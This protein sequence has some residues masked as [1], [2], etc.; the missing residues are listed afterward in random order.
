[1]T[2]VFISYA[3]ADRNRVRLIAHGLAAEG[4]A[5]W[6]DP[7]IKPGKKWN[8]AIRRALDNAAAVV[9]VWS[10]KSVKSDWV[11]AET[12]HGNARKAL[13]PV[14]I[15][16]CSPPIPYNMIQSADLT[17]WKGDAD[18]GEW[19]AVLR[20]VRALV[21]AK[22]RLVA[23]A[24][25]P[26]EAHGAESRLGPAVGASEDV[27]RY[28]TSG[29]RGR[30]GPRASRVAMGAVVATVVISGGL[31]MAQGALSEMGFLAPKTHSAATVAPS[32]AITPSDVIE[33]APLEDATSP[34][35]EPIPPTRT[36][37]PTPA[38]PPPTAP[39]PTQPPAAA[40]DRAALQSLDACAQDFARLCPRAPANAAPTGFR[41]DGALAGAE[42]RFLAALHFNISRPVAD[43]TAAACKARLGEAAV[44]RRRATSG[45]ALADACA[46][47]TWPATTP[48][49][50]PP[51]PV[52]AP[53]RTTPSTST[54]PERV[55][56]AASTV[57]TN[58]LLETRALDACAAALPRYCPTP[59]PATGF[60]A[61]GAL[62]RQEA[63]L[64]SSVSA[65]ASTNAERLKACTSAIASLQQLS[66]ERRAAGAFG[67]ACRRLGPAQT[68]NPNAV[69]AV[70]A[71]NVA[72][73]QPAQPH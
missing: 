30:M 46:T 69:R 47:L 15:K 11:V 49:A 25:P 53:Q 31:W 26:G 66:A 32:P 71:P 27:G 35:V 8:D 61:D 57:N 64:L 1:M 13:V 55:P 73:P 41:A 56:S 51:P 34:P 33:V 63:M 9:T 42:Q 48:P 44:I 4:F 22:R 67:E 10:P 40:D 29:A 37:L 5:V 2:D 7:E 17:R 28:A 43:D 52:V 19:M 45:T 24:P 3:R 65:N 39:Q 23:G 70:R 58:A 54:L 16:D 72:A 62:S 14:T 50:A 20:Q 68:L 38:A 59:Q 60:S 21:E 18:D 6:W 12:T 36:E